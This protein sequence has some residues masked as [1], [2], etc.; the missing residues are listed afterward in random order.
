[1]P[2]R[3]LR[4]RLGGSHGVPVLVPVRA[5]PVRGR[6]NSFPAP[7]HQML[8]PLH[9]SRQTSR[10]GDV[11]LCSTGDPDIEATGD[12]NKRFEAKRAA[13][14]RLVSSDAGSPA[15]DEGNR[16]GNDDGVSANDADQDLRVAEQRQA[17]AGDDLESGLAE[18]KAVGGAVGGNLVLLAE[19][20]VGGLRSP[21]GLL[22]VALFALLYASGEFGSPAP[23]VTQAPSEGNYYRLMDPAELLRAE[24]NFCFSCADSGAAE[25][26]VVDEANAAWERLRGGAVSLAPRL[27]LSPPLAKRLSMRGRGMRPPGYSC[28]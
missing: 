14:E 5:S 17:P 6:K 2:R 18:L 15:S 26:S 11:V 4:S 10:H 28:V 13:L 8:P 12:P 1:M 27:R 7:I 3:P 20:C 21:A 25:P 22:S 9:L 16:S 19:I 24:S 23:F